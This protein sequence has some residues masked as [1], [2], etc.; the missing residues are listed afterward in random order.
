MKNLFSYFILTTLK[1]SHCSVF[2]FIFLSI[3]CIILNK[4]DK[5][6]SSNFYIIIAFP[7]TTTDV[8]STNTFQV[9]MDAT[10]AVDIPT[11]LQACPDT[12]F[13]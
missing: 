3:I 4:T 2:F 11:V 10:N 5:E 6:T 8:N 1:H 9:R 7:P 13:I 12:C